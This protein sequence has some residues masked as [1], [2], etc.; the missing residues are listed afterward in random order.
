MP[1]GNCPKCEK[2][3]THLNVHPVEAGVSG[4]A[5]HV[6]TYLCPSCQTVVG[7]APDPAS[8]G[9]DL[10]DMVARRVVALLGRRSG[11]SSS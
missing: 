11:V 9:A 1:Y 8:T 4:K 3:I 6:V 10:T 7:A 5:W 2:S